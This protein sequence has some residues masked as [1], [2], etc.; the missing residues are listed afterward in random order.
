MMFF[1]RLAS[2]LLLNAGSQIDLY[3]AMLQ[4]CRLLA[5][6]AEAT[7]T[8]LLAALSTCHVLA[9]AAVPGPVQLPRAAGNPGPYCEGAADSAPRNPVPGELT[10]FHNCAVSAECLSDTHFINDAGVEADPWRSVEQKERQITSLVM[11]A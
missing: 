3:P 1:C 6:C 2:R 7:G 11:I 9:H 10:I 8:I 4:L 5:G